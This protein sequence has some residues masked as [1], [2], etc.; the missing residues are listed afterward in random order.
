MLRAPGPCSI[1]LCR[2]HAAVTSW[3]GSEERLP[4]IVVRPPMDAR[5]Q[6][7]MKFEVGKPI[8]IRLADSRSLRGFVHAEDK[9]AA[10]VCLE[11]I[12]SAEIAI[13]STVNI[14]SF[15]Y[16]TDCNDSRKWPA[17][18]E[19]TNLSSNFSRILYFCAL[20]RRHCNCSG[21]HFPKQ[22]THML[23]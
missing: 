10:I 14:K 3:N 20:D 17:T 12:P 2:Q 16:L 21:P 6:S 22:S 7:G 8:S 23:S 1:C 15:E 5:P 4:Q 13:V 9:A 18:R 19:F 11:L